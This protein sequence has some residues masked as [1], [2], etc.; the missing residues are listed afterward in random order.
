MRYAIVLLG[1]TLMLATLMA[2][3]NPYRQELDQWRQAY[4][5]RLMAP[6][7][8]LSV[9]GLSWLHQ[10]KNTVGSSDDA[11]VVL[12]KRFAAQAGTIELNG[13]TAVFHSDAGEKTLEAEK[14]AVPYKDV[15]VA[16]IER[17]HRYAIRLRDPLAETRV[18]FTGSKWFPTREDLRIV[19][20]WVPYDPPHTIP[21]ASILGYVEDQAT[22]GYAEFAIDGKTFRLEPTVETPGS[23]FFTFKDQTAGHETYP[24]GRFLDAADPK[25]GKVILDFNQSR[26]PPCAFTA[27]ATCPLPP[28]QNVMAIRIEA[29]ELRYGQH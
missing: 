19:A 10:G 12:P 9:A 5:E 17:D 28:K 26:N 25:D 7:G 13:K 1:T 22:P 21:I 6:N 29:G 18:H 11:D 2:T 4:Q 15:T 27:Y 3:S 20:K 14:D 8:W 16:L 23:L 24:A